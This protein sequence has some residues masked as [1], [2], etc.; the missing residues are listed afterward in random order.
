M[1]HPRIPVQAEGSREEFEKLRE[2]RE[3]NIRQLQNEFT[4]NV[5]ALIEPAK[6]TP[7]E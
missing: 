1:R 3:A 7:I 6:K 5:R 2:E 4:A